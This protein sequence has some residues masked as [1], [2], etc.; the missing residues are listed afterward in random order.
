MTKLNVMIAS[1]DDT[2]YVCYTL[3]HRNI[4]SSVEYRAVEIA[5]ARGSHGPPIVD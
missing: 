5:G 4:D 2:A 1:P 3:Q